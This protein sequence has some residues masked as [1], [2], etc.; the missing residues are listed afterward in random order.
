M[1]NF[2]KNFRN[3]E[4]GAVTVDWVVMTALVMG[5]CVG[6]TSAF[7]DAIVAG[8]AGTAPGAGVPD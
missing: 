5:L 6:A 7:E 3:D 4:N 8:A 2:I 1:L